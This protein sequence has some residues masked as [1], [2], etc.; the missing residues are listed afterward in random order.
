MREWSWQEQ[1]GGG[2][3]VFEP[4]VKGGL[5]NLQLLIGGGSSPFIRNNQSLEL[6]EQFAAHINFV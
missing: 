1:I 4:L 5:F 6:L 3:S 2:L